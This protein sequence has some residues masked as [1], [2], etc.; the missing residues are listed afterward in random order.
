MTYGCKSLVP[1]IPQIVEME[2]RHS[3]ERAYKE[4]A[5]E[6][7]DGKTYCLTYTAEKEYKPELDAYELKSRLEITEPTIKNYIIG[8]DLCSRVKKCFGDYIP[9]RRKKREKRRSRWK[10]V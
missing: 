1:A 3:K 7:E 4:A 8:I 6:L 2:Q 5:A 10:S 9:D